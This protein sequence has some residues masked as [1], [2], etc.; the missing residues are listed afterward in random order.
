MNIIQR[1]WGWL[2]GLFTKTEIE[3]IF[4][5]ELISSEMKD[6]IKEWDLMFRNTPSWLDKENGITTLGHAPIIARELSNQTTIEF[7]SAI[8]DHDDL[9]EDYQLLVEQVQNI[10]E[11]VM[12]KGGVML[13]PFAIDG[14]VYVST[15]Q[16]E[17]FDITA[18]NEIN[19]PIGV[20]FTDTHQ[21]GKTLYTKLEYHKYDAKA[22]TET[23][24]HKAFKTVENGSPVQVAL[25]ATPLWGNVEPETTAIGLEMPLFTYYK[26]PIVQTVDYDSPLG[27][28]YYANC[29]NLIRQVDELYSAMLWEYEGSKLRIFADETLI[30]T[31]GFSG[32]LKKLFVKLAPSGG[33]DGSAP[34]IDKFSPDI[35]FSAYIQ[36]IDSILMKIED[37][38]G[39]SRATLSS[40]TTQARTATEIKVLKQ[41]TFATVTGNQ[42]ALRI[43]LEN[44]AYA[45]FYFKYNRQA[46]SLDISFDFDDSIINDKE[47][48]TA[49]AQ[50]EVASGLRSRY[51]YLTVIRNMNEEEAR[52][53]L[54]AMRDEELGM[55]EQQPIDASIE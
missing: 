14:I 31:E 12:A 26:T 7:K 50:L 29:A 43:A 44:T 40:E 13:K 34:P 5:V 21:D 16:P 36:G 33:V 25:S 46:E 49:L 19:Q 9:N 47:S 41:R 2:K 35:R 11:F 18:V 55:V 28:S 17:R 38:I 53:E 4:D 1:A 30:P 24:I 37:S 45:M 48:E 42:K 20:I 3:K 39:L 15:Y 32:N 10:T 6:H 22:K 27:L 23:I 52:A 51:N 54:Q 8:A